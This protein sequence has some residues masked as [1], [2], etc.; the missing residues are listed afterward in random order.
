MAPTC[1]DWGFCVLRHCERADNV[2]ALLQGKPWTGTPDFQHFPFDPPLSDDGLKAARKVASR[3]L[4]VFVCST[5]DTMSNHI[6][7]SSPYWRCIQTA[8]EIAARLQAATSTN[9]DLVLDSGLA[10]VHGPQI[11]SVPNEPEVLLRPVSAA[12]EYCNELGVQCR[13]V[14]PVSKSLWPEDMVAA[15]E[16]Y[17][18][19]VVSILKQAKSSSTNVIMVTHCLGIFT[20]LALMRAHVGSRIQEIKYG[21]MFFAHRGKA[22]GTAPI[23]QVMHTYPTLGKVR[24]SRSKSCTV[25]SH[26]RLVDESS[27]DDGH[28][29]LSGVFDPPTPTNVAQRIQ[30]QLNSSSSVGKVDTIVDG[31]SCST[32]PTQILLE[33]D[34]ERDQHSTSHHATGATKLWRVTVEGIKIKT[35]TCPGSFDCVKHLTAFLRQSCI[36]INDYEQLFGCLPNLDRRKDPQET[37]EVVCSEQSQQQ[38]EA[39]RLGASLRGLPNALASRVFEDFPAARLQT[40]A[41][42]RCQSQVQNTAIEEMSTSCQSASTSCE[43]NRTIRLEGSLLFQRRRLDSLRSIT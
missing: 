17:A 13:P 41:L 33:D 25:A 24:R 7:V 34:P 21:G 16:R 5:R 22:S 36:S 35:A 28:S 20:A 40:V 6:V 32:F 9:V 26:Q 19:A 8:A 10:E 43:G 1:E 39:K 31:G 38:E 29:T 18:R 42:P 2:S 4:G 30:S 14:V 15:Q 11:L 37:S 27:D 3:V 12:V 23:A